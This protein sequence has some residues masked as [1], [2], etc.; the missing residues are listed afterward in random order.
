MKVQLV[1][2]KKMTIEESNKR[3]L[4]S[5]ICVDEWVVIS[6]RKSVGPAYKHLY[7][8][9]GTTQCRPWELSTGSVLM[10]NFICIKCGSVKQG[11][12]FQ[13][14]RDN[15][16]CRDCYEEEH[17]FKIEL[18]KQY[19]KLTPIEFVNKGK[20]GLFVSCDCECGTKGF[21]ATARHIASG[22]VTCC[23][24]SKPVIP[25]KTIPTYNMVFKRG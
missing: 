10:V 5:E 15:G 2:T 3:K 21:V 6:S 23:G 16:M 19:D 4:I 17:T 1:N 18:G 11:K 8:T 9:K 20:S 14:L 7:K 12:F 13:V 22:I 25:K 24:C